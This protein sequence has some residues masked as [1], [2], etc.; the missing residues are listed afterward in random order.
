MGLANMAYQKSLDL[1]VCQAQGDVSLEKHVRSKEFGLDNLSSLMK[2]GP[3]EHAKPKKPR[4]VSMD[5]NGQVQRMDYL[6]P[7]LQASALDA[8]QSPVQDFYD[9]KKGQKAVA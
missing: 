4:L 3:H 5:I 2:Y 8:C 6:I 7:P 9:K 1:V